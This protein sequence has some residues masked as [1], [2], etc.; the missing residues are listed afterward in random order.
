MLKSS[1]G[2]CSANLRVCVRQVPC[3]PG[4][5]LSKCCPNAKRA[6]ASRFCSRTA[7]AHTRTNENRHSSESR[8]RGLRE[9]LAV[10]F[11]EVA[12]ITAKSFNERFRTCSRVAYK[13]TTSPVVRVCNTRYVSVV[14]VY[15]ATCSNSSTTEDMKRTEAQAMS[16][17]RIPHQCMKTLRST[18]AMTTAATASVD[19]V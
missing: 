13:P 19:E 7:V 17:T 5:L 18:V 3:V 4:R 14:R 15:R 11:T 16:I 8:L 9:P 6:R 12:T 1:P 10:E 2:S